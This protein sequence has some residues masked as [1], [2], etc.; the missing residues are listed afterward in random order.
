MAEKTISLINEE[1]VNTVLRQQ[2][3]EA[4]VKAAKPILDKAL[5]E[6]ELVMQKQLGSMVIGFL[7]THMEVETMGHSIRILIKHDKGND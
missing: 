3:N 4:M 1:Y 2:M 6:M 7:D 5:K